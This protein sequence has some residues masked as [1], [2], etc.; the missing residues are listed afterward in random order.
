ME[1]KVKSFWIIWECPNCHRPNVRNK[2]VDREGRLWNWR[3]RE[4]VICEL[5]DEKS[6]LE[7]KECNVPG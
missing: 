7:L 1:A 2:W 3:E 4:S 5:C 6:E